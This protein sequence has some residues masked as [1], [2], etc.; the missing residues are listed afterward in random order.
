MSILIKGMCMPENCVDCKM[1]YDGGW[2]LLVT[3]PNENIADGQ[4]WKRCP[5]ENRPDWCPLVDLPSRGRLLWDKHVMETFGD[6]IL[7]E[8][9][10][11]NQHVRA[12]H[13]EIAAVVAA[14]PTI[15]NL[16]CEE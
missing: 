4:M 15:V 10:R 6:A 16:E 3:E 5:Y 2:C 8:A 14:V 1:S 7:D 11:N 9:E 12:T 13:Q